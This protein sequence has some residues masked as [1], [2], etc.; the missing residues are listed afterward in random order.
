M[1]S[2]D[3]TLSKDNGGEYI[4]KERWQG[5][6]KEEGQGSSMRTRNCEPIHYVP[7][8]LKDYVKNTEAGMISSG[9][10]AF[11]HSHNIVVLLTDKKTKI[12]CII[13]K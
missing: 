5:L 3:K 4:V 6:E 7:F 12:E 11:Q 1:R 10:A 2:A 9:C 13:L 8:F